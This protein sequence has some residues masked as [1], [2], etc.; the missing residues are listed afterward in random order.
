MCCPVLWSLPQALTNQNE[1]KEARKALAQYGAR[2]QKRMK[3]SYTA[4]EVQALLEKEK[5][6]AVE[7]YKEAH[8]KTGVSSG[9]HSYRTF[10][11]KK[12]TAEGAVA[13]REKYTDRAASYAHSMRAAPAAAPRQRTMTHP[14]DAVM[15]RR[16]LRYPPRWAPYCGG[17]RRLPRP[18][19]HHRRR[20]IARAWTCCWTQR[21]S[22][23]ST[24][25][26][27]WGRRGGGR[28]SGGRWA[29]ACSSSTA[30]RRPCRCGESVLELLQEGE[31]DT[32]DA[33]DALESVLVSARAA[34]GAVVERAA[35]L[36][37]KP[38]LT[39]PGVAQV[40]H[41]RFLAA[42]GANTGSGSTTIDSIIAEFSLDVSKQVVQQ[43]ARDT[44]I[45]LTRSA[46]VPDGRRG[47]RQGSG[48][49]GGSTGRA[50]AQP[51][52][53]PRA[54]AQPEP[55]KR[56]RRQWWQRRTVRRR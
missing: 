24:T 40:L 56:W 17:P 38:Q 44:A 36:T 26:S 32:Y 9:A 43:L 2:P 3:K 30:A 22:S 27:G 46:T 49:G 42:H 45:Q 6:D 35:Y 19:A 33:E 21:S 34:L 13:G 52:A 39:E 7:A 54:H 37:T 4:A 1:H 41:Q 5:K 28:A 16:R 23:T 51:G 25:R 55:R 15:E 12:P 31:H 14:N 10:T 29:R 47:P 11:H 8:R 53:Q 18:A 50:S 20:W 48:R